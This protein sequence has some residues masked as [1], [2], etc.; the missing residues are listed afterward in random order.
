MTTDEKNEKYKLWDTKKI[1]KMKYE[2]QNQSEYKK[3][4]L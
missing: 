4:Q 3:Y 2:I 1:K